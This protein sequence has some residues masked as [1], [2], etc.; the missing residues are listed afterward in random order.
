MVLP[1]RHHYGP[2]W[3][4]LPWWIYLKSFPFSVLKSS[5]WSCYNDVDYNMISYTALKWL[6]QSINQSFNSPKTPHISPLHASYGVSIVRNLE[7]KLPHY[8]DT[9][10]L[11]I[12]ILIFIL[13]FPCLSLFS[14]EDTTSIGF[15]TNHDNS[16]VY[17]ICLLVVTTCALACLISYFIL[18]LTIW[19]NSLAPGRY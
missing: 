14:F 19:F 6:K 15:L 3:V 7:K 11:L 17:K 12:S 13:S 9:V 18:Y 16:V 4:K 5:V 2:Q 1:I 10:P 8:N